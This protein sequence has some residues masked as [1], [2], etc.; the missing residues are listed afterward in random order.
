M[1]ISPSMQE[2]GSTLVAKSSVTSSPVSSMLRNVSDLSLSDF[3]EDKCFSLTKVL[4]Y[5]VV[6]G[7]SLHPKMHHFLDGIFED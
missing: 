2:F 3:G 4:G 6:Y 1:D 5:H 7:E